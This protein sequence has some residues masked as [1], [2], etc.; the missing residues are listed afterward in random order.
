MTVGDLILGGRYEVLREVRGSIGNAHVE[1]GTKGVCRF[2]DKRDPSK[3]RN[4]A[5]T[6]PEALGNKWVTSLDECDDCNDAFSL[7]DDAL[8]NAVAPFLTLGG[9][10]GK[11]GKTRQTGRSKG[12]RVLE[13]RKADP[14]S[15]IFVHATGVDLANV[16]GIGLDGKLK[17]KLPIAGVPFRP[18]HA[19]KALSKM[20]F[21]LL[22]DTELC[23]YQRLRSWL[24]NRDDTEEFPNLEVCMSFDWIG[25]A[26]KFAMGTLLRRVSPTDITPHILFIFCAGSVCFQIDLMSDHKEDHLPPVP[27]GAIKIEYSVTVDG[28]DGRY[29]KF[30]YRNLRHFNWSTHETRPQPIDAMMLDFDPRTCEGQLTP[31]IRSIWRS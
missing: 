18:R 30:D 22:P 19:Y 24:L 28:G 5:H 31:I 29:L 4:I 10:E 23:N 12:D 14:R 26:P 16:A 20:G 13:R 8:A 2:C 3:F 6:F 1:I 11:G 9:V 17:F 25:N 15:Q 21:A 27:R 7:Y